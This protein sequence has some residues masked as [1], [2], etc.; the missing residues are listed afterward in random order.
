MA[1]R[2]I[3]VVGASAGGVETLTR[4]VRGFRPDLQAAVLVVLH[5]PPD[6]PSA[7]AAILSRAGPLPAQQAEDGAPIKPGHIYVAR[8]NHHLPVRNGRVQVAVGPRENSARPAVD[9]LFRS[10]ARSYGARVV[11]IVLSGTLSDGA[12]GLA[13]IKRRG[14]MA[15]VQDPEEAL[16]VGM[17]RSALAATA[18]D[19]C[20]PAAELAERVNNLVREDMNQRADRP[21][22]DEHRQPQGVLPI[23]DGVVLRKAHGNASGI[24]CPECQGSIWEIRDGESLRFECR[25]GHAY[26]P[27][28]F[29]SEQGERVEAALW[30]AINTLHERAETFRRLARLYGDSNALT[31][32]YEERA[33]ETTQQAEVL[34]T[35]LYTL[36][37]DD[38]VG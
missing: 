20:A 13:L 11:G 37:Q 21:A 22:E 35:L 18:V 31:T 5:M 3:V 12:A 24:T 17:P 19:Y 14:G 6:V 8:P 7:L 25:V 26:S 16:F 30:T 2:D 23:P 27:D 9:V 29:V 38:D 10:A 1:H 33:T 28:T 34:R 4:L 32:R 36:V 15:L